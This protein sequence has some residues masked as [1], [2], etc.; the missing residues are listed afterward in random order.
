MDFNLKLIVSKVSFRSKFDI[1]IKR[2]S[3]LNHLLLQWWSNFSPHIHKI[4]HIIS[5]NKI[6]LS[7]F[8][9][10]IVGSFG[11]QRNHSHF[12]QVQ[13]LRFYGNWHPYIYSHNNLDM[14]MHPFC[15]LYNPNM[16]F[17]SHQLPL[18]HRRQ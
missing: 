5:M 1:S 13:V 7:T 14:C 8:A 12:P 6:K 16:K 17:T 3:K 18:Q 4:Q 10:I 9:I 2:W 15:K 11:R